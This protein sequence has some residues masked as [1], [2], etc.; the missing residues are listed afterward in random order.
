MSVVNDLISDLQ[1]HGCIQ[2]DILEIVYV[3]VSHLMIGKI[4]AEMM[5]NNTFSGRIP[6]AL[7]TME[8]TI[9]ITTS[10]IFGL[11]SQNSQ[12]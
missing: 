5:Q 8:A 7:V 12:C 1:G 2:L 3:D 9:R 10:G 6:L 4:F 11:S